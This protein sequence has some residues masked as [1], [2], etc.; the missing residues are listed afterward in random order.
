M[1]YPVRI[2]QQLS[3]ILIAFRKHA[4]LSQAEVAAQLGVTQQT[5]SDL[6]R[7]AENMSVARLMRLLSLLDI[8]LVLRERDG[9]ASAPPEPSTSTPPW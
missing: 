5:V 6:E 4:G 9:Q 1:D 2:P 7:N 8:V 3:S